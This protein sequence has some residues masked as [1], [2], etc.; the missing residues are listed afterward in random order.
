LAEVE[1]DSFRGRPACHADAHYL[2]ARH[3]K[4]LD[5]ALFALSLAKA[6]PQNDL[7]NPREEDA[8]RLVGLLT[9]LARKQTGPILVAEQLQTQSQT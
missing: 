5:R 2:L 3:T 8:R 6:I 9:A 1:A 7:H 4:S